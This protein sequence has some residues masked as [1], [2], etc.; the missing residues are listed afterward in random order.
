MIKDYELA[1]HTADLKLYAYGTTLEELFKNA[2]KGMFSCLKPHGKAINYRDDKPV[3]TAFE[4]ERSIM[5][6][7]QN[8]EELLIDFLS[9]CLYLSD[10]RKEAYFDA[11]FTLLTETEVQGIIFG[12]SITGF[13]E[14]EIKAVTYHELTIEKVENIW[15][16]TLVFDI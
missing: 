1:E 16:A 2:L 13:E 6:H 12:V 8:Q 11:R 3:V 7:S 15:Q 4:I 10:T 5:I 14:S 9:E